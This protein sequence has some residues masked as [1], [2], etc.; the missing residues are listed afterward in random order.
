MHSMRWIGSGLTFAAVAVCAG[1]GE[2][3][4]SVGSADAPSMRGDDSKMGG[5]ESRNA[6]DVE[7]LVSDDPA[8]VPA[9]FGDPLLKN[10]WG[11]AAGPDTFWWVADA[12]TGMATI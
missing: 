11:L 5:H 3:G 8:I 2:Q 9:K 6:Y 7:R 12:E 10:A 1:C 4:P